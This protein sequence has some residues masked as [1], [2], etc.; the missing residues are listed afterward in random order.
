M[1][2]IVQSISKSLSDTVC[3][4]FLL[5]IEIKMEFKIMMILYVN[6]LL[7]AN[8]IAAEPACSKF[9]YEEKLLGKL[10]RM[11]INFEII[12]EEMKD[13]KTNVK[14]DIENMDKKIEQLIADRLE[15]QTT[16]TSLK[17]SVSELDTRTQSL[18]TETDRVIEMQ[19]VTSAQVKRLEETVDEIQQQHNATYKY[20]M[21]RI[22]Y[23]IPGPALAAKM[24][25]GA[26]VVR[27]RDWNYGSQDGTPPGSGTI[28]AIRSD[29]WHTVKWDT[30]STASYQVDVKK[31]IYHLTLETCKLY[32]T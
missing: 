31:N 30:T 25:V 32:S 27:G 20:V 18:M 16:L 4:T 7:F 14:S 28:T 10:I 17:S 19:N 26:R 12:I 22:K 3:Y 15:L 2:I 11:E 21:D 9:D 29:I 8:L 5:R 1:N 6:I 13:L 24:V 23:C